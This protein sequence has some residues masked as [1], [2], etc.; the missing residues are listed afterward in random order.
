MS[1]ILTSENLFNLLMECDLNRFKKVADRSPVVR[2]ACDRNGD[3]LLHRA[4]LLGKLD[5]CK[6]LLERDFPAT[7][8]GS[9]GATPLHY[10]SQRGDPVIMDA[11]L[12]A[13]GPQHS[14]INKHGIT[15]LHV[16]AGEGRLAI[17][18]MLMHRGASG[19]ARDK[20]DRLPLHYAAGTNQFEVVRWLVGK[21]NSLIDLPDAFGQRPIHWALAFGCFFTASWLIRRGGNLKALDIH[22]RSPLDFLARSDQAVLFSLVGALRLGR[23]LKRMKPLRQTPLQRAVDSGD[24][25]VVGRL[26]KESATLNRPDDLGRTPLHIAAFARNQNLFRMV[27]GMGADSNIVDDYGWTPVKLLSYRLIKSSFIQSR[28][29]PSAS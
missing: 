13:S 19:S 1:E 11:L 24:M 16:A 15:P 21:D 23:V 17:V 5:A 3:F 7:C 14:P 12:S 20:F 22:G 9:G 29:Y 25:G 6:Y 26:L 28:I 4:V 10:A 2:V 8:P 27:R 18:K